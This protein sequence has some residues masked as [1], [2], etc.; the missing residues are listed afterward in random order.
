[1]IVDWAGV[2]DEFQATHATARPRRDQSDDPH[3]HRSGVYT[4]SLNKVLG[5]IAE[6]VLHCV[7]QTRGGFDKEIVDI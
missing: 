4:R 2:D 6:K 1:M 5:G 7:A 3:L